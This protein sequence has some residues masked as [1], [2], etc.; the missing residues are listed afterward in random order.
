VCGD[1]FRPV[2]GLVVDGV[3]AQ[4]TPLVRQTFDHFDAAAMHGRCD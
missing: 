2:K 4:I 1:P 3:V